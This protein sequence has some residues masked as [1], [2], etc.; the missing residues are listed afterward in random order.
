MAHIQPFKAILYDQTRL[1]D[2][3][4][5]LAPPYDVISPA[6][7][8]ALYRRHPNN[9]V[10]IDFG[11]QGPTDTEAD[12]RYTRARN[13][14][15]SWLRE[16]VLK[17][18]GRPSIY[19]YE[20][21][22][23]IQ[24][25]TFTR[26]AFVS[27]VRLEPYGEGNIYPHEL[28]HQGPK[29][30]RLSLLN[31]TGT[32][33]SQIFALYDD[34]GEAGQILSDPDGLEPLFE[35]SEP[36]RIGGR[37]TRIADPDRI[38]ALQDAIH[39][40]ALYIADGHHR[41][42]TCLNYRL[43]LRAKGIEAPA[44][45]FTA[46]ACVSMAD[47]GLVILPTHRA[48]RL[49]RQTDAQ[50]FLRNTDSAFHRL[51]SEGLDTLLTTVCQSDRP[52]RIGMFE[53]SSGYSTL[54]LKPGAR[55]RPSL[56]RASSREWHDL[57]VSILHCALLHDCMRLPESDLFEKGPIYYSHSAEDCVEEVEAGRYDAAFFLRPVSLDSLRLIVGKGEKMPPK[58][59]F[60]YPK[61]MSGVFGVDLRN[62]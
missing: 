10:R 40:R 60:F 22:F 18:D 48:V 54:E 19:V 21:T 28:T 49:P 45:D 50:T 55:R 27:L 13:S 61:L 47:P 1:G 36:G 41:Y 9:I 42:E 56:Y 25:Q 20:Q 4:D 17:R 46:M 11:K 24:G 12:N 5:V 26:R 37:V 8:E 59:T 38:R 23:E 34:H 16:G 57:D 51:P 15:D 53:P 43:D 31:A 7:Q 29:Q 35:F 32:V 30:D 58:S 44:G 6:D 2:L 14:L 33:F 52:G 62:V 39:P 3:T